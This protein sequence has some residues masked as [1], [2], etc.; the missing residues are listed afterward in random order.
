[1][2]ADLPRVERIS[3]L[4]L[5]LALSLLLSGVWSCSTKGDSVS[6]GPSGRPNVVLILIDTLRPDLL[7][8]YGYRLPV[9]PELDRLA[10]EGVRFERVVAQT[11]WTRP[12]T[13]SILTSRYPRDLGLFTEGDEILP[14]EATTLAE[15]LKS[16][17]Y[18]TLG[19]TANPQLNSYYNFHQGFDHYSDSKVAFF[20]QPPD[21]APE[22]RDPK[23]DI[24]FPEAKEVLPGLVTEVRQRGTP[25]YYL[26]VNLME[27]HES[28][29]GE[30][31]YGPEYDELYPQIRYWKRRRYLQAIRAVSD[32]IEGFIQ[33][34]SAAQGFERT[35]F[36]ITSD[37]GESLRDHKHVGEPNSHGF[38]VYESQ[39]LVPMILYSTAGDLPRGVVIETPV[40]SLDLVPTILDFLEIE[41]PSGLRG[42][43]LLPLLSDP[44]AEIDLPV[45]FV[46]ETYFKGS[47]K[48][49]VYGRD[50]K[51]VENRDGQPGTNPVE[52][53]RNDTPEN[54]EY[55]DRSAEY[56]ELVA[57]FAAALRQWEQD[58]AAATPTPSE[59]ELSKQERDQLRALGYLD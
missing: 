58:H 17:G 40:R 24:W 59:G 8:A 2:V 28:N 44:G 35:L 50:W 37:H 32:A 31:V 7:G 23:I 52:L 10:Q 53:H 33:E 26:Q 42:A 41:S 16:A 36:V 38:L 43:S 49:A 55:T 6:K 11:T 1:M 45:H 25:P 34:L 47:D 9:S 29:A 39:A 12:S 20:A 18:T 27:V 13:A 56:P 4:L 14:S 51:Y 21:V 19:A 5:L 57:E 22:K 30:M 54:G 48:A 46:V 15:V 3:A